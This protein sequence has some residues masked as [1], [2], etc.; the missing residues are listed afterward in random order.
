MKSSPS[1]DPWA[2]VVPAVS[3][4]LGRRIDGSHPLAIY[5]VVSADGAPG[6]LVRGIDAGSVPGS[7]PRPRGIALRV[8]KEGDQ[9]PA[10]S[11]FLQTP[12]DRDVFL[13]LC[14]DVIDFSGRDTQ[15]SGATARIFRRLAHWQS[16][17]SRARPDELGQ[18]Q[19]RGL[20]GELWLLD[21][22][23]VQIGVSSAL[24]A[25]VAPE[26]H[27][28]DF[29]LSSAIIE[30]KARLAGSR[31]RVSISS[32]EQLET[33]HL[34]LFLLVVELSPSQ[35][36]DAVSLN[37]MAKKLLLQAADEGVEM[38]EFASLSLHRR[39]YIASPAYDED[40][41]LFTGTQAFAVVDDFPR[42]LR[43]QTDQRVREAT[44]SIDLT[45]L[46]PYRRTLDEVL[47]HSHAPAT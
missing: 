35:V 29:A 39:G 40:T 22:L 7:L 3:E 26:D 8:E 19:V 5:W 38:E 42:I 18:Q 24:R 34:P 15:I 33:G 43:S 37:D 46:A 17:L 4:L 20:M 25:W 16:L 32:L 36:G 12:D 11:L 27:P 47:A 31:P 13:A 44:Y 21:Q 9:G 28:Q 14:R 2:T 30:A 6:L 45:A 41:Y 23:L 10:M 1:E